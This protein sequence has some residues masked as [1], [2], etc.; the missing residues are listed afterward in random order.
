VNH[1]K[2]QQVNTERL[3]IIRNTMCGQTALHCGQ[4]SPPAT[5]YVNNVY[6]IELGYKSR[7]QC[8]IRRLNIKGL[9]EKYCL[10][11]AVLHIPRSNH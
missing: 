11:I 7:D 3:R 8:L 4:T 2:K 9:K 10:P 6:N 5:A 1:E